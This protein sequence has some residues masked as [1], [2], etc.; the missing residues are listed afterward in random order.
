VG[1]V[2]DEKKHEDPKTTGRGVWNIAVELRVRAA[3]PLVG[4]EVKVNGGNRECGG[5]ARE[6]DRSDRQRSPVA[7]VEEEDRLCEPRWDRF[8]RHLRELA[9]DHLSEWVERSTV[10]SLVA[11]CDAN[12]V[13][14]RLQQRE[15]DGELPPNHTPATV[16]VLDDDDERLNRKVHDDHGEQRKRAE[17]LPGEEQCDNLHSVRRHVADAEYRAKREPQLQP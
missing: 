10:D 11:A 14:G 1:A 12:R 9:D 5:D 13:D 7:A 8:E 15:H 17:A 6:A 16:R 4:V 3:P 2:V